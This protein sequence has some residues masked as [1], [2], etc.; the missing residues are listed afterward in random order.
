M[1]IDQPAG[2]RQSGLT[3]E[4]P[5]DPLSLAVIERSM[6]LPIA[7][8]EDASRSRGQLTEAR[9]G[10]MCADRNDPTGE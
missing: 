1:A 6:G 9:T 10:T 4:A 7:W 5:D 2:F 3:T 8:T